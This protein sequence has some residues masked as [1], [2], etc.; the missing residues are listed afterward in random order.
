MVN[1]SLKGL[2]EFSPRDPIASADPDTLPG[3]LARVAARDEDALMALYN[4]H[5]RMVYAIAHRILNNQQDAEEVTQ[6]VFL[7]LWEKTAS[8]DPARGQFTA[9]L[10]TTTRNAALDRLRKKQRRIPAAGMIS[11]DAHPQL[12]ETLS[13][14]DRN[15]DLLR[16]LAAAVRNLTPEQ[17]Q[18]I[19]LAY[20]YDM[21]H[22]EIAQHLNRP[23]GTI[24]SHIRQ[25][26]QQLRRLWLADEP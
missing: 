13:T 20:F 15:T 7:K 10:A 19:Q 26:M 18:A 8:Y 6:D 16:Q 3:L 4:W 21:T 25:G 1:R 17:Q 12:W 9:W 22:R 23:L 24:K 11:I 5:G 2:L 14:E